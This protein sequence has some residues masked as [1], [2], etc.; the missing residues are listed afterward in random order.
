MD[1]SHRWQLMDLWLVMLQCD[2]TAPLNS[3]AQRASISAWGVGG[4]KGGRQ[5]GG[6]RR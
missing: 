2:V 6:Q 4:G 5:S 1:E 3:A